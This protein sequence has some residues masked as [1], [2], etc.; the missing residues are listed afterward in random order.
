MSMLAK[1][2]LDETTADVHFIFKVVEEFDEM[3]PGEIQSKESQ[4]EKN[5]SIDSQ[6]ACDSSRVI[7]LPAHKILLAG[8]S[9][10]FHTMFYGSLK[11]KGDVKITDS[12]PYAFKEFLSCFYFD[13]PLFTRANIV[14]VYMITHKYNA[15][16]CMKKV[17]QYLERSL[18]VDNVLDIYDVAMTLDIP[19]LKTKCL[20]IIEANYIEMYKQDGSKQFAV[21]AYKVLLN[22]IEFAQLSDD[23]KLIFC[24]KWSL[25]QCRQENMTETHPD[26]NKIVRSKLGRATS[27]IDFK[28]IT[29]VYKRRLIELHPNFFNREEIIDWLLS[30]L[31]AS[32]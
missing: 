20:L 30:A 32:H 10:V 8:D 29:P 14:D 22:I 15:V 13:E 24:M 2:Y 25:A 18:S 12:T 28:K 26:F 4:L 16:K 6:T 17:I 3:Q 9:D 27:F 31:P 23:A 7:R 1:M 21:C 19:E 11:E 5:G